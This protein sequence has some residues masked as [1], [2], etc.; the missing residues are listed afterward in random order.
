MDKFKETFLFGV[1][2][3]Y[4]VCFFADVISQ[5]LLPNVFYALYLEQLPKSL[6]KVFYNVG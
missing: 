2:Q 5:W 4:V 6:L 1:E 3:A